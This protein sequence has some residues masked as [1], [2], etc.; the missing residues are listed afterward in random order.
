MS[1]FLFELVAAFGAGDRTLPAS[2]PCAQNRMAF[3][4][5]EILVFLAVFQAEF[6]LV[7]IGFQR[8]PELKEFLVFHGAGDAILGKHPENRPSVNGHGQIDQDRPAKKKIEDI[9]S[10]TGPEQDL[11]Q[12]VRTI[13]ALHELLK[14]PSQLVEKT[15]HR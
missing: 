4:A 11:G 10:Q 9:E 12:F 8:I 14:T 3:R 13:P 2:A 6:A 5:V 1:G 15:I 7:K